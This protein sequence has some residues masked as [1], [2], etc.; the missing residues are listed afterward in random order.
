M[1]WLIVWIF[2]AH[3]CNNSESS[4][5]KRIKNQAS[6]YEYRIKDGFNDLDIPKVLSHDNP[7]DSSSNIGK[8]YQWYIK[9]SSLK[10]KL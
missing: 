4:F 2:S 8:I 9:L 3:L 1:N 5:N 7:R 10:F 6:K